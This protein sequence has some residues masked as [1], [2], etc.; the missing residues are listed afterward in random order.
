MAPGGGR[1]AAALHG[2]RRSRRHTFLHELT[3]LDGRRS[4]PGRAARLRRSHTPDG[5][6]FA[7]CA[8]R[9]GCGGNRLRGLAGEQPGEGVAGARRVLGGALGVH[10]RLGAGK[11]QKCRQEAHEALVDSHPSRTAFCGV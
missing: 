3:L 6:A 8:A 11:G 5:G 4:D 7:L 1:F 9:R 10:G 2:W